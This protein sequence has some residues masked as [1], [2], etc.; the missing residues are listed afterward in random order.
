MTRLAILGGLALVAVLAMGPKRGFAAGASTA[1]ATA[2][3][4]WPGA[5][6]ERPGEGPVFVLGEKPDGLG[7]LGDSVPEIQTQEVTACPDAPSGE[8]CL[9]LVLN[10][11]RAGWVGPLFYLPQP[12]AVDG[13]LYL[14]GWVKVVEKDPEAHFRPQL[15]AW[16]EYP[17]DPQPILGRLHSRDGSFARAASQADPRVYKG[18]TLNTYSSREGAG[19]WAYLWS[20]DI[21]QAMLDNARA[22]YRE[23]NQRV[24]LVPDGRCLVALGLYVNGVTAGKRL[25]LLV[26]QVRLT[27]FDPLPPLSE[28]EVGRAFEDYGRMAGEFQ[29][30]ADRAP[31][32]QRQPARTLAAELRRLHDEAARTHAALDLAR[33]VA[34][35]KEAA[36]L[37]WRL[38]VLE[39][40]T[41]RPEGN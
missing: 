24:A 35:L 41:T 13:P 25:E 27:P 15:I 31:E 10:F 11:R 22:A 2:A 5:D 7:E 39:I 6:F 8:R 4:P 34:K 28:A 20:A 40:A 14:S 32:P 1:P 37:H 33:F 17:A 36:A 9:R 38:K 12:I 30:L 16:G 21:N 3:A 23:D 26:D 19:G 29:A 18:F